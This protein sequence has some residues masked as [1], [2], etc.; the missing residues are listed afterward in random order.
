MAGFKIRRKR[1]V[2]F[3]DDQMLLAR[4]SGHFPDRPDLPRLQQ[5]R[6]YVEWLFRGQHAC[7]VIDHTQLKYNYV[8]RNKVCVIQIEGEIGSALQLL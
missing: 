2:M 6:P 8:T 5:H 1:K 4:Q 7:A 3:T